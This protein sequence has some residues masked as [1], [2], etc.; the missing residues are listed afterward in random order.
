M[1]LED[2]APKHARALAQAQACAADG[3][4]FQLFNYLS[5]YALTK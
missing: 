5:S 4:G 1:E 2:G 3:L